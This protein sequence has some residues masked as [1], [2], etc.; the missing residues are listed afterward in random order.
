MQKA[1][2]RLG[3]IVQPVVKE[4]SAQP[5]FMADQDK[6]AGHR[7]SP[8]FK[9]YLIHLPTFIL[10]LISWYICYYILT[11][12]HPSAIKNLLIHNSYFIFHLSFF[13][14]NFFSWSFLFLNSRR[15][16]IIA[17]GTTAMLFLKLQQVMLQPLLILGLSA[18]WAAILLSNELMN[19]WFHH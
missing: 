9:K 15:G 4:A 13:F 12:I 1:R 18:I 17:L 16:L 3:A 8:P 14:A 19:R 2:S 10:A 6:T 11:R 7:L 5:I